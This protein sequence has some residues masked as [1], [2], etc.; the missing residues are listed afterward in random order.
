MS[1]ANITLLV[2]VPHYPHKIYLVAD[3]Q[4]LMELIANAFIIRPP[5]NTRPLFA[6]KSIRIAGS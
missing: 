6:L 5:T 3:I 4:L 1:P 2:K